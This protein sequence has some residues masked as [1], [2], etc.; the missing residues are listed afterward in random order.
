[1]HSPFSSY[2]TSFF[3]NMYVM[4][5]IF[6]SEKLKKSTFRHYEIKKSQNSHSNNY[7]LMSHYILLYTFTSVKF[8][9]FLPFNVEKPSVAEMCMQ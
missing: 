8:Q 5:I 7:F 1:M 2:T 6:K 9:C 4:I 3:E